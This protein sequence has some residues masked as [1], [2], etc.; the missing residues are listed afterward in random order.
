MESIEGELALS[1]KGNVQPDE[2]NSRFLARD[3]LF[4]TS[5]W[6]H[7]NVYGPNQLPFFTSFCLGSGLF[8]NRLGMRVQ[9]RPWFNLSKQEY[10]PSNCS[11]DRDFDES[12]DGG[13]CLNLDIQTTDIQNL[14]VCELN[15]FD[16]LLIGFAMKRNHP[17]VDI[18]LVLNYDSKTGNTVHLIGASEDNKS[19][20]LNQKRI[21][22][23]DI[24]IIKHIHEY[25]QSKRDRHL[26]LVNS[27]NGW[28]IR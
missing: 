10:Q 26:P 17:S 2:A 6:H 16:T 13:S 18:E 1:T 23:A 7:L 22:F 9:R 3:R 4:W 24:N 25:V 28:E 15:G 14:F 5:F 20:R 8:F 11:F 21:K 19:S 12:F 27:I